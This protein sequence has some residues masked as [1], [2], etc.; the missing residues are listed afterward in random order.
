[1][2]TFCILPSKSGMTSFEMRVSSDSR[3]SHYFL[4]RSEEFSERNF[5][6]SSNIDQVKVFGK[7][8][9][10]VLQGVSKLD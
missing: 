2:V 6:L 5:A 1:M 8:Y 7:E 3:F 4:G 9:R 10:R